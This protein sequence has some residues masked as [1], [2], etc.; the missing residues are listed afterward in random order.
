MIHFDN[1][2][3]HMT[4]DTW[5]YHICDHGPLK[6]RTKHGTEVTTPEVYEGMVSKQNVF[7]GSKEDVKLCTH[8]KY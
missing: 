6:L 1:D 3:I 5:H 7:P 4:K 2:M 8:K